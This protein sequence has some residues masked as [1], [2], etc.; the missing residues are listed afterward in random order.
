MPHVQPAAF[1]RDAFAGEG[2]PEAIKMLHGTTTL[3]FVF[4]GGIII[5]VD[6][7]ASQ[8]QYVGAFQSAANKSPVSSVTTA[9]LVRRLADC[10]EG[11]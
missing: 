8:G 7:R 3:G 9:I 2:G 4:Q 1:M 10:Q 6:S 5:C 11:D